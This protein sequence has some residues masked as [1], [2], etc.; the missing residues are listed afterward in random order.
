MA[1][2]ESFGFKNAADKVTYEAEYAERAKDHQDEKWSFINS[3]RNSSLVQNVRHNVLIAGFKHSYQDPRTGATKGRNITIAALAGYCGHLYTT[4]LMD[5]LNEKRVIMVI[6]AFQAI[7]KARFHPTVIDTPHLRTVEIWAQLNNPQNI[8]LLQRRSVSLDINEL[9]AITDQTGMETL[10]RKLPDQCSQA[11]IAIQSDK[12]IH[13][14][15]RKDRKREIGIVAIAIQL[16]RFQQVLLHTC[17]GQRF[18]PGKAGLADHPGFKVFEDAIEIEDLSR[19]VEIFVFAK[20]R[21][22]SRVNAVSQ[23]K[24]EPKDN[25]AQKPYYYSPTIF[26]DQI[27]MKAAAVSSDRPSPPEFRDRM[28]GTIRTTE[29]ETLEAAS[30]HHPTVPAS[31]S[32]I[33][34]KSGTH[35]ISTLSGISTARKHYAR[36]N[37]P[38]G[39]PCVTHDNSPTFWSEQAR[40]EANKAMTKQKQSDIKKKVSNIKQTR[41]YDERKL[42]GWQAKLE[43]LTQTLKTHDNDL[44]SLAV[45]YQQA[46]NELRRLER[47]AKMLVSDLDLAMIKRKREELEQDEERI[48]KRK[49]ALVDGDRSY[50]G[51]DAARYIILSLSVK[52]A[53]ISCG[54]NP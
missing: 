20:I 14:K 35:D 3:N 38:T 9:D 32:G 37:E 2:L 16:A 51:G 19:A 18:F 8:D 6:K 54:Q 5:W 12:S 15:E 10:I 31:H 1:Q 23:R 33:E 39:K 42:Q 34:P 26:A 36:T 44:E 25:L 30:D 7:E 46:E 21:T 17:N 47:E 27:A 41:R 22:V 53:V 50:H 4:N 49:Q 13:H 45:E 43:K 11:Q 24:M 52:G 40:I 48:K 28:S 29:S